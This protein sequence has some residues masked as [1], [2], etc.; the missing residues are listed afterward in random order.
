MLIDRKTVGGALAG[1]TLAVGTMVGATALSSN[2]TVTPALAAVPGS[3][4]LLRMVEGS[5]VKLG[6]NATLA[7]DK[8]LFKKDGGKAAVDAS[9]SVVM[10]DVS[11]P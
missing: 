2:D 11:Y 3:R 6:E 4:T 1:V 5:A 7:I 9:L 10:F 8:L